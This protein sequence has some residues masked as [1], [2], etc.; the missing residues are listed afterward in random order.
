M[1][2][3]VEIVDAPTVTEV[4]TIRELSDLYR[5]STRWASLSQGTREQYERS[6]LRMV[7]GPY[8]K[9]HPSVITPLVADAIY[10]SLVQQSREGESNRF[11]AVWSNVYSF[12]NATEI[13]KAVNPWQHVVKTIPPSRTEVWRH[14]EMQALLKACENHDR[15]LCFFSLLYD[16]GQ[17]PID[18]TKLLWEQVKTDASG[19]YLE[20]K[21]QKTGK[22]VRPA[23]SLDTVAVMQRL[24]KVN[25]RVF[26][27]L[28]REVIAKF[29]KKFK[30]AA[31]VRPQLQMRDIRRTV[32]T[33]LGGASDDQ[34]LSVTGH[35]DRAMLNVYSMKD[36][37]KALE[38]QRIRDEAKRIRLSGEVKPPSGGESPH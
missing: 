16:T 30:T 4:Q 11:V 33:E 1:S 32:V 24:P 9:K 15:E 31:G 21:Q 26:P 18:I 14:E 29:F 35:S 28:N 3:T 22:L 23:V 25:P 34:I 37:Q 5:K 12:G 20:I 27:D 2:H 38:A 36:R 8:G 7:N 17:R 10:K 13:V 6:I 19:T